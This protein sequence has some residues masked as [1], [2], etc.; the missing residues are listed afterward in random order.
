MDGVPRRTGVAGAF[1][2]HTF[3]ESA[4]RGELSAGLASAFLAGEWNRRGMS[5]RARLSLALVGDA[6]WL[7]R[8][9]SAVLKAWPSAPLHDWRALSEFIGRSVRDPRGVPRRIVTWVP[10][11]PRMGP[12]KWIVPELHTVGDVAAWLSVSPDELRWLSDTSGVERARRRESARNYLHQ[13]VPRG[14]KLP[15][16]LEAPKA[17]L[18]SLQRKVLHELL[19]KIPVHDAAHGFVT[20]RSALTHARL[21]T[22]KKVVV[23]FDLRHFFTSIRTTRAF[24][25]LRQLGYTHEVSAVLLGLCTTRTPDRVLKRAPIPDLAEGE[26]LHARFEMLRQL[27]HWHF[28]QGAPTSPAWANV[29][30]WKIDARLSAYAANHGLTYSRYADD[31]VFSGDGSTTRLAHVVNEVVRDEGFLINAAKTK[32]MHAHTRQF[33]TGVVVNEKPNV[34]R[35]EFDQLKALIHRCVMKGGFSQSK[36]PID[37]FRAEVEGKVAW[38]NQTNAARGAKLKAQLARVDWSES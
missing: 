35:A 18:K 12:S 34:T 25:V 32:V 6:P 28:P 9:I 23:R 7:T 15:R 2:P 16:L 17:K 22:G 10:F 37:Q 14:E 19:E 21:H 4:L 3:L 31:L 38:V 30:A 13:W 33:V 26:Q 1:A 8:L 5:S 36:G 29:C 27:E 24:G 11:T 20:G